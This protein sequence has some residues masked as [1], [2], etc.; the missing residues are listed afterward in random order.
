MAENALGLLILALASGFRLTPPPRALHARPAE[1]YL[2]LHGQKAM[3]DVVITPGRTGR[4]EVGIDVFDTDFAPI[5]PL[6]VVVAFAEPGRGIEPIEVQAVSDGGHWRAGP[7]Q[8]PVSGD[9][10]VSVEI[11]VNDFEKETL[12]GAA[13]IESA[14]EAR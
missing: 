13:R 14:G 5:V 10:S 11:L 2:H 3:A 6:A 12:E 9:W 4:N 7:V 8:L 1:V